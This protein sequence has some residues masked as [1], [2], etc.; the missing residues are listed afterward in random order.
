MDH[1]EI[2]QE[3]SQERKKILSEKEGPKEIRA[4]DVIFTVSTQPN[5][6]MHASVRLHLGLVITIPFY[7]EQNNIGIYE[8]RLRQEIRH[9]IYGQVRADAEVLLQE[10]LKIRRSI[11]H[12][13]YADLE[14]DRKVYAALDKLLNAGNQ[15]LG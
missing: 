5:G 1:Q 11:F 3:T 4:E 12:G 6:S 9:R 15:I 7:G 2:P 10:L 8:E 13:S 14:T